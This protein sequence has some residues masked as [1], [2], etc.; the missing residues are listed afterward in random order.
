MK[1]KGLEKYS[2]SLQPLFNLVEQLTL[3][4]RVIISIVV[5]ALLVGAFVFIAYMPKFEQIEQLDNQYEKVKKKLDVAKAKAAQLESLQEEWGEKQEQFKAAM[6]AL[7]DKKE[8]PSLLNE[9]SRAGNEAGLDFQVFSPL[10]EAPHEFYAEI[11][12]ALE[13]SGEYASI[14][15]FFKKVANMSRIVNL[16][17]ISMSLDTKKAT[18]VKDSLFVSTKCK[19]VTYRF[20]SVAEKE[21]VDDKKKKKKKR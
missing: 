14:Y 3:L 16:K 13:I 20:L 15:L 4:Q 7:P 19:A 2:D 21:P 11:P 6:N 8:I 12:V 17:D 9:I 18:A 5:M 10:G 1:K